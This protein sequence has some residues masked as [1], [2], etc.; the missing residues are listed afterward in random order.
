MT[1]STLRIAVL[2]PELLG[3]YGDLGNAVVLERRMAWRGLP[4]EL[5]EVT[6]DEPVP[7]TCDLYLLGGG[8]DDA[9]A[10]ALAGLRRSDGLTQAV[11]AGAQVL[12]VC[13]GLQLLGVTITTGDGALVDGIGLLDATTHRRQIRAVGELVAVPDPLL[14]LPLLTGFENH[15]GGTRLGRAAAPLATVTVGHGNGDDTSVERHEGAQQGSVLAT[16]LHGPV[17]ARNPGLADLVL[18]RAM[19]APLAPLAAPAVDRLRRERL[20]AQSRPGRRS[21]DV[22]V[23]TVVRRL[24]GVLAPTGGR[25]QR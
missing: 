24:Q 15:A 25:P 20:A 8:E 3:T 16:Y 21:R 11:A 2:Y 7:A 6:L 22:R 14:D 13:A 12:A 1:P 17:L 19:G 18:S 4:V 23:A 10:A 5:V 9:Q